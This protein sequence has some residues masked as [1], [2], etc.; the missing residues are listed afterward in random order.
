MLFRKGAG[1]VGDAVEQDGIREL[2]PPEHD[3]TERGI[4]MVYHHDIRFNPDSVRVYARVLPA[5]MLERWS[6]RRL[7]PGFYAILGTRR[8]YEKRFPR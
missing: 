4:P 8:D 5:T 6:G 7:R 1:I 3:E 2:D